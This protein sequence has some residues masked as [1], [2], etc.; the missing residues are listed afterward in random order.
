MTQVTVHL[1]KATIVSSAVVNV[2]RVIS[3]GKRNEG[4]VGQY[5]S[6]C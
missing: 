1:K 6:G 3:Q 2:A 5:S 4:Y